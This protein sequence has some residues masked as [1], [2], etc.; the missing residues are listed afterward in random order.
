MGEVLAMM[1]RMR[2][3]RLW[4]GL[5]LALL[6]GCAPAQQARLLALASPGSNGPIGQDAAGLQALIAG[7]ADRVVM[8]IP[9]RQVAVTLLQAGARDGVIRWRG[10]DNAQIQTR[11]GLIIATRG[12][13]NDL[14]TADLGALAP[15]IRSGAPGRIIRLHRV[16][17]GADSMQIQSWICD[18][19]PTGPE[20][21]R[22]GETRHVIALRVAETC[23]GPRGG[24]TNLHWVHD[25]AIV[26]SWQRINDDPGQIQLLFLP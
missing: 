12:L 24:F 10:T 13:S 23:H 22:I 18:I 26:Q 15:L 4:P 16:L 7:G 17:D 25:G 21:I 6:A 9:A 19:A 1:R 11:D 8:R 2:M 20:S 5:M 14:M 3:P